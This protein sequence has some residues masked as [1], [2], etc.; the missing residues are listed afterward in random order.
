MIFILGTLFF[1]LILYICYT[2]MFYV[3][4]P[5]VLFGLSFFGVPALL[6]FEIFIGVIVFAL[7]KYLKFLQKKIKF[8]EDPMKALMTLFASMIFCIILNLILIDALVLVSI[9]FNVKY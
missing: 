7:I 6:V 3:I 2:N 8:K 9:L 5:W 4:V 1:V